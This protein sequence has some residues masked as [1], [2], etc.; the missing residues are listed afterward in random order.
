MVAT[1][2]RAMRAGRPS[3]HASP[4]LHAGRKGRGTHFRGQ[5]LVDAGSKEQVPS[6]RSRGDIDRMTGIGVGGAYPALS[7]LICRMHARR[8]Y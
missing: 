7:E 3:N 5:R 8:I 4:P 6:T 1:Q 2:E